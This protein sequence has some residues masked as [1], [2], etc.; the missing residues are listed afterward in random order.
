[1]KRLSSPSGGIRF[2]RCTVASAPCT[3]R[4]HILLGMWPTKQGFEAD[5]MSGRRI[6]LWLVMNFKRARQHGS[7][8][9]QDRSFVT[10]LLTL[11]SG[12]RYSRDRGD[13]E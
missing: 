13:G 11:R 2:C 9:G 8:G 12:S 3:R 7:R 1:M 6:S 10:E 5:D 4:S